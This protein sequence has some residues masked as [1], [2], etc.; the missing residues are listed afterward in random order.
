MDKQKIEQSFSDILVELGLDLSDSNLKNTPARL[1]KL[2]S[3]EITKNY[4]ETLQ[5]N[6]FTIFPNEKN[7]DEIIMLDNIPFVSFC[8]H[9]ALPFRGLGYLLYIPDQCLIGAS[10]PARIIDFICKKPQIQENLEMEVIN[11]FESLVKP[12][13]CMLL[14]RA[15]HSCIADRGVKTGA[16]AGMTTDITRG[17]FRT[18]PEL[19]LKGLALINIANQL[20]SHM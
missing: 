9:H 14:M 13:G 15:V 6:I 18:S 1:M 17:T 5:E 10:K 12:K 2:F 16:R 19:E 8:S 11:A 4:N 3:E 20:A 7:Y